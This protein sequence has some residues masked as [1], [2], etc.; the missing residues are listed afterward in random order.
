MYVSLTFIVHWIIKLQCK[1][2]WLFELYYLFFTSE[3]AK[4]NGQ[5]CSL[6]MLIMLKYSLVKHLKW[7]WRQWLT[8]T[9][10]FS[11]C[12]LFEARLM[13]H[14]QP[15]FI[16]LSHE[17]A[18]HVCWYIQACPESWKILE[19]LNKQIM[20]YLCAVPKERIYMK[21]N[22]YRL[23]FRSVDMFS[24]AL[25]CMQIQ[26][27]QNNNL[28]RKKNNLLLEIGIGFGH[29]AINLQSK[30]LESWITM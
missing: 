22:S 3:L 8:I 19:P 18:P 20:D 13:A 15:Q 30:H 28:N 10:L 21:L 16:T 29:V 1:P 4:M 2:C 5:L 17:S 9:W 26:R 6:K 7:I 14:N 25:R 27:K 12:V 23:S 24:K 11:F